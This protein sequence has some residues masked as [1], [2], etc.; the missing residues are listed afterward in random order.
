VRTLER[1]VQVTSAV[2]SQSGRSPGE[3]LAWH[4]RLHATE[5][6][7]DTEIDASLDRVGL[8][9]ALA[10]RARARGVAVRELPAGELSGGE[11]RR[12]ALA[13]ALARP[14]E[15]YVLDEP[16]AGLD[17]DARRQLVETLGDLAS[18]ARVVLVAHDRDAIPPGFRVVDM[19]APTT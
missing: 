4:C 2:P 6:P 10:S 5:P 14:R 9:A 13:R 19:P 16:E 3:S 8:S 17:A 7:A 1:A 11:R 18:R 12:L 15:L